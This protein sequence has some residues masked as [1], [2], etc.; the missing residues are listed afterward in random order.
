MR[1]VSEAI[2]PGEVP[3]VSLASDGESLSDRHV[4]ILMCGVAEVKALTLSGF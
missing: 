2:D 1:T 3:D 4:T